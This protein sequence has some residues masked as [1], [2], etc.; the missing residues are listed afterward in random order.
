[1]NSHG[2]QQDVVK[3]TNANDH[4]N[5]FRPGTKVPSDKHGLG[6]AASSLVLPHP[7]I[8]AYMTVVT[9]TLT[10]YESEYAKLGYPDPEDPDQRDINK[11]MQHNFRLN[12]NPQVRRRMISIIQEGHMDDI[13]LWGANNQEDVIHHDKVQASIR[14]QQQ[15]RRELSNNQPPSV[16]QIRR[17][18]EQRKRPSVHFFKAISGSKSGPLRDIGKCYDPVVTSIIPSPSFFLSLDTTTTTNLPPPAATSS[19]HHA[20]GGL[21]IQSDNSSGETRMEINSEG[22]EE[23]SHIPVV[24]SNNPSLPAPSVPPTSNPPPSALSF[25]FDHHVPGGLAFQSGSS[26]GGAMVSL[27]RAKRRIEHHRANKTVAKNT[28]KFTAAK[29]DHTFAVAKTTRSG[30]PTKPI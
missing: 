29:T 22:S 26:G 18:A 15:Q 9:P 23:N 19:V 3:I 11:Q 28:H 5:I 6:H 10:F 2:F 20:T 13:T 21:A 1:M 16:W 24:P 4:L 14:Q 8:R 30:P 7:I 17:Q 25:P 12:S 27:S